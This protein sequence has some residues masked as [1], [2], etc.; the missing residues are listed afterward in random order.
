[1][2]LKIRHSFLDEEGNVG[3]RCTTRKLLEIEG[4]W[5]RP[6]MELLE[7]NLVDGDL[8]YQLIKLSLG[9]VDGKFVVPS[10]GYEH[11]GGEPLPP[12]WANRGR[13]SF[14][15]SGTLKSSG[16]VTE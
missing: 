8:F 15:V 4:D 2:Q 1:M 13:S 12:G 5:L 16:L 6:S 7:G 14:M 3:V 10:V 11:G 9:K